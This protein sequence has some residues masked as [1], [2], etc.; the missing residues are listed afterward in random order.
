VSTKSPIPKPTPRAERR[1]KPETVRRDALEAGR[2]LLIAGGPGAITLKAVGA[3]LGMSHANLI[4]HFGSAELFRAQ[5]RDAM[6]EDLTSAVAALVGRG[7]EAPVDVAAI[8]ARVFQAYRAD[9]IGVL[10]AWS[11]LSG[12]APRTGELA[13]PL[14]ELV[15]GLEPLV[16]GEDRLRRAREIVALATLLAFADSLIGDALA[17]QLGAPAGTTEALT[18]R[19]IDHLSRAG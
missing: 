17:A 3:E 18:V 10:M 7:A 12:A 1:R 6:V 14:G 16:G 11:A 5:L 15:A 4:H 19:L 8:V 9:G 13:R 2:R